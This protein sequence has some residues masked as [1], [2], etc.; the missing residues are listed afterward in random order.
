[1]GERNKPDVYEKIYKAMLPGDY[2]AMRLTGEICTTTSGLSEGILWNFK[3]D[4]IADKLLKYYGIDSSLLPQVLPTFSPQGQLNEAAAKVLGLKPGIK[5]AYRAGD[6]PNNAFS[7]NVLNKGEIAA[8]AGTSGVVYGITDLNA[9]DNESRVNAFAHVN[10]T[11]QNPLKGV[12]FA[13]TEQ[14]FFTIG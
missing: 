1:M 7:L 11:S 6:Q 2:V 5:V 9:Y 3:E 8:T 10:Y 13:L 4:K 14:E 12:C